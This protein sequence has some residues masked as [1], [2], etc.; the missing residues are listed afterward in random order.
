[1]IVVF[2]I[3]GCRMYGWIQSVLWC[4]Y[5]YTMYI[6]RFLCVCST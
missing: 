2:A 5:I 6:V 3:Y 4:V 1:V